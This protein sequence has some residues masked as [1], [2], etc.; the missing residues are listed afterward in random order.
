M[1]R[2]SIHI[3]IPTP[4]SVGWGN[5]DATELGA[6]CH[7]C[8]KEVIDYSAMTDREVIEYLQRHKLGCGR[9]REDQL[10]TTLTMPKARSAAAWRAIFLSLLSTLSIKNI[11]AQGTSAPANK[12]N[13]NTT[14]VYY[15]RNDD[16]IVLPQVDVISSRPK[17]CLVQGVSTEVLPQ[18]KQPENKKALSEYPSEH[19]H[20]GRDWFRRVFRMKR[21][22]NETH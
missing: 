13:I 2:T 14:E 5:M 19:R 1:S 16:T 21:K 17:L 11:I 7:S 12:T 10:N 9:F 8:Q 20:K 18:I 22:I 4:C 15:F 6:F 3:S